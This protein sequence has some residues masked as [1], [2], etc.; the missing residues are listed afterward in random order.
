M[1]RIKTTRTVTVALYLLRIY[2]L[3]MLLIILAKF[4]MEAR[5]RGAREG[6]SRKAVGQSAVP[7]A[8]SQEKPVPPTPL[9][10]HE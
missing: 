5:G 4:I 6:E 10:A 9:R 1:P 8:G 3:A 7:A 2:L